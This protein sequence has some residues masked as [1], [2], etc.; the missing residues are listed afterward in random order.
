M[1]KEW[2]IMKRIIIISI[3]I[4][5]TILL[6]S[7]GNKMVKNGSAA[8]DGRYKTSVSVPIEIEGEIE[9]ATESI[10]VYSDEEFLNVHSSFTFTPTYRYVYYNIEGP[11]LGLVDYDELWKWYHELDEKDSSDEEYNEM[12]LV[13]FIKH[14]NIS[15]ENFNV[16]L[17]ILR[18]TN[19]KNGY[20]MTTED[21]EL[22]NGYIIY[23]FDNDII[24]N[25]YLRR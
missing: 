5:M 20:D 1:K 4:L 24:N 3:L 21:F 18:Q 22:P 14:F 15:R 12:F 7:C 6:S 13:T 16:A 9:Y 19:I 10:E 25:Y 11:F 8:D 17:E 23:T 2:R